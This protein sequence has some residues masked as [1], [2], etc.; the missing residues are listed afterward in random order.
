ME[1][2]NT[3]HKYA[4]EF[5]SGYYFCF[6]LERLALAYIELTDDELNCI[7]SLIEK[8]D[9]SATSHLNELPEE[10]ES[11]LRASLQKGIYDMII[12]EVFDEMADEAKEI[13]FERH[14]GKTDEDWDKLSY[15]EKLSCIYEYEVFEPVELDYDEIAETLIRKIEKVENPIE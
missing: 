3:R 13:Y 14:D 8:Y 12:D 6:G 15:D 5:G 10:L 7:N 9:R 1:T 11:R 2:K 4:I